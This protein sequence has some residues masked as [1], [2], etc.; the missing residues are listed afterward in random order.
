MLIIKIKNTVKNIFF[1]FL[2]FVLTFILSIVIRKVFVNTFDITY[3]GYES[4][5]SNIF[6][7]LSIAEMGIGSV[8]TYNLYKEIADNNKQEI[9]KLLTIYKY[10]YACIGF[11]VLSIGLIILACLKFIIPINEEEVTFIRVIYLIQLTSILITYFLSYKRTLLVADQKEYICIKIDIVVSLCSQLIRIITI[12]LTKNYLLYLLI[13]LLS[14]LISNIV[15][16]IKIKKIYPYLNEKIKVTKNDISKR[17][18]FQDIKNV[19]MMKIALIVY[20]STDS[21]IIT[22]ILGLKIVAMYSNYMLIIG[23]LNSLLSGFFRPMQA[24]VGNIVYSKEKEIIEKAFYMYN[25]ISFIVATYIGVSLVCVF[26]PFISI[27]LGDKYLLEINFVIALAINQYVSYSGQAYG[28]YRLSFGDYKVDKNAMILS[29]IVN[30]VLSIFLAKRVGL[31][32][33]IIGT[34][35]GHLFFQYARINFVVKKY[36]NNSLKKFLLEQLKWFCIFI[37][38]AYITYKIT[39]NIEVSIIGVISRIL[40]AIIVPNSINIFLFRRNIFFV[41]LKKYF[42]DFLKKGIIVLKSKVKKG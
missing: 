37:F 19:S 36:L 7:M 27:W 33:V 34:I 8:I 10:F 17:N 35:I 12:I 24:V 15:I 5:F 13:A 3:L 29:A 9:N 25:F 42:F 23:G 21:I 38:E 2:S 32:G 41:E 4:L 6:A 22:S 30:L 40:I 26:Q 18:L 31:Y 16:N 28:Q 14:T 1:S 39:Q 11:I 20:L